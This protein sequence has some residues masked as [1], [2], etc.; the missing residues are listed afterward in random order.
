MYFDSNF[1]YPGEDFTNNLPNGLTGPLDL[2]NLPDVGRVK[3]WIT[4]EPTDLPQ[5]NFEDWAPDKPFSQLVTYVGEVLP[6][7]DIDT[8]R[9]DRGSTPLAPEV[10][11]IPL[12][13][14][15]ISRSHDDLA[16]GNNWPTM[17]FFISAP[18]Q[19]PA[20]K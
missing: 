9:C 17:K 4:M 2:F 13:Y 5:A 16:E 20:Q 12:H 6:D 7:F 11:K 14:R 8:V 1:A 18:A 10:Y 19:N 3:V 15:P